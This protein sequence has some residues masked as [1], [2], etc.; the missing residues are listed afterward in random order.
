MPVAGEIVEEI[1]L[2]EGVRAAHNQHHVTITGAGGNLDRLFIHPKL[3]LE[4]DEAGSSVRIS[5]RMPRKKEKALIGT[6]KSHVE[7]MVAGVTG[8]F[9]CQL[10]IVY[11]HFPLKV[12]I[13][14]DR[15]IIDNFLGESYPRHANIVGDGTK[16]ELKGDLV[17]VTGISRESV[18]QTAA[19]IEQATKIKRYDPRVF[20]DGIYRLAKASPIIGE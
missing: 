18:S 2:P 4:V 13:K 20:Q 17:T 7:N 10:K 5:C 1:N 9:H 8:G 16:V 15:L 3:I 12:S 19:N 11:A 14:G 6:W